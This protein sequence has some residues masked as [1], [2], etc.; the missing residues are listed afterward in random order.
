MSS[1]EEKLKSMKSKY[2]S[3]NG[4]NRLFKN[5]QKLACAK[6]ITMQLEIEPLLNKTIYIAENTNHIHVDYTIFKLFANPSIYTAIIDHID[7]LI[8]VCVTKYNSS[9][10]HV[11]L[12]T[13]TITAAHRHS[14]LIRALCE[15]TLQKGSLYQTELHHIYLY[16]YPSIIQNIIKLFSGF[17][18]DSTREKVILV[19]QP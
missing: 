3:E 5:S 9:E 6:D 4:T 19:K 15:K 8:V 14:P 11:N 18:D 10:L 1:I 13:F 7:R 16:N 12:N 17:V 2:Y